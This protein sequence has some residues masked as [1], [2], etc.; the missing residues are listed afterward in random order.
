MVVWVYFKHKTRLETQRT[1]RLALEKGTELSPEFIK[2]LG[3]PE[4]PKERDLR[5]GL[6]WLAIG[7]A[8]ALFAAILGE[9]DATGPLLGIAA[10]PTLVGAAY[11]I[12]WNFGRG[13]E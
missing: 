5:R 12:M 3:E 1:Y 10:F 4:P 6:I 8:T 11:L 13:K 7:V 2:Q 9:E